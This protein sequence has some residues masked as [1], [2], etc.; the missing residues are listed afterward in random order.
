MSKRNF[1][2]LIITLFIALIIFFGFLYFSADKNPAPG[3]TEGTNFLS[4]FNPFGSGGTKPTNTPPPPVDVSGYQPAPIP[5]M[6]AR[7]KKV[8]SM[9]VAGFTVYSKERLVD[10]PVPTPVTLEPTPE[11]SETTEKTT[12]KVQKPTPPLTEFAPT[13]RYAARVDGNIYQTF[14]DKIEE[15]RFST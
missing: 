2:L 12:P 1:I 9:P 8:S 13:L 11:D 7:L 15:R 3:D 10:V 14:A 6:T 4:Q 5:D